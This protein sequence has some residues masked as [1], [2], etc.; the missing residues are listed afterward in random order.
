ML[1]LWLNTITHRVS[2][3]FKTM[4]DFALNQMTEISLN[5]ERSFITYFTEQDNVIIYS[6]SALL[7]KAWKR[8]MQI[9]WKLRFITGIFQKNLTLTSEKR[10]WK[11]HLNGCFWRR[12]V[13]ED[14][15]FAASERGYFP[16]NLTYLVPK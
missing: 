13:F 14:I 2:F 3:I 10:Y 4:T 7:V 1:F 11:M 12:F 9:Y 8:Y 15:F 6:S 5:L 16:I